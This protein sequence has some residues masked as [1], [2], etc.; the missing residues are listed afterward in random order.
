M[1]RGQILPANTLR[2][3]LKIEL[4]NEGIK[5][6]VDAVKSGPSTY[7]LVM[8]DSFKEVEV[9]RMSDGGMLYVLFSTR[10]V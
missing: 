6:N 5:Y 2:N 4:I 8:N 7:F 9:H 10:N 1:N 3:T